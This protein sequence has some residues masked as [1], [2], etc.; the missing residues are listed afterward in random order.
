MQE[1]LNALVLA[2]IYLLFALGLSLSWGTIGV[3]N[4]AH[5][6]LFMFAAFTDYIVLRDIRLP[7]FALAVLGGLV[8]AAISIA[9]YVLVYE[10]IHR[11]AR[12]RG[13]EELQV[14]I[15]G[16]GIAGIPLAIA[17]HQTRSIPFGFVRSSFN[18]HTSKI[19]DVRVTNAQMIIVVTT[20]VI[21]VL[22][23]VWL[24]RSK[25]GLALRAIGYDPETSSMM[26]VNRVPLAIVTMAIS[27]ALAGL[28]GVLLTID[29]GSIAPETGDSLLLKGFAIVV[30]GG[31]GSMAGGAIGALVLAGA[32]TVI[33]TQTAGTWVDAVSFAVI[34]IVLLVRPSGLLNVQRGGVEA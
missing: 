33:L 7:L 24:V 3:V 10:P 23:A 9:C 21:T 8:G 11:R 34:V 17:Q 30:L 15:G 32:E 29:F 12:N 13:T 22:L 28:A 14:L 20:L 6:S 5:G 18:R 19:G 27:G 1:T 31:V 26:G 4:F 25:T 16:I 2:A